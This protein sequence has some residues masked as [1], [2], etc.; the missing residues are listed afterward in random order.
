M[1]NIIYLLHI[2]FLIKSFILQEGDLLF[3]DIDCGPFCDAIEEVTL[4]ING[5]KLSHIGLVV[6]HDNELFVLEAISAGVVLTPI[7][8]FLCRS[9]DEDGNPKVIVGRL[10]EPFRKYIS[11]ATNFAVQNIGS[12]YDTV[13]S[14]TNEA[15]YCS[16]LIYQSF[17]AA[18]NTEFFELAPM[19]FKSPRTD[20]IFQVWQEYF[21]EMGIRVPEG[22]PG[23]NPG[24]ISR[25]DKIKIVHIY[26]RPS[27]YK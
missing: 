17:K 4:G 2:S 1:I 3:Q 25:S 12:A 7:S 19:S 5:A 21:D 15:W 14:I 27:G 13:F 23:I 6:K 8:D 18:S 20:S 11:D 22:E 16:E 24:G 10:K 26:G 9:F